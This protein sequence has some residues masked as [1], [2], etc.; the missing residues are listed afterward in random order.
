M[1]DKI[2]Q[3]RQKV[4]ELFHKI[5]ATTTEGSSV[6]VE[7]ALEKAINMIMEQSNA[8]GK[9]L[10]I[11]NGGSAAIASHMA[12]DFWKNAGIKALAF[13]DSSLLTCISNDE[14][15]EN[16]FAKPIEMFAES[17][18]IL[19][20]VSSSGQSENI[21]RGVQAAKEKGLRVI[22]FSGFKTD[23]SLRSKGD[24]NF[25]VP[26]SHYGHVECLHHFLIHSLIDVIHSIKLE[27]KERAVIHE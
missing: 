6:L 14:G 18:D 1:I 13:N 16:V 12:T 27:L 19:C 10:F 7:E 11:G 8:E 2:K 4:Q 9:L 22:T 23:N 15:Y 20:A 3:N 17:N 24:I 25:Y 5:Q 21:L 26:T